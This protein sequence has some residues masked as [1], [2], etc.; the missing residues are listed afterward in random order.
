M[1]A[2]DSSVD[3]LLWLVT[4]GFCARMDPPPG[5]I[6]RQ[7]ALPNRPSRWGVTLDYLVDTDKP[8]C[9]GGTRQ[10]GPREGDATEKE[11]RS[12]TAVPSVFTGSP[13]AE[14]VASGFQF[15][16]GPVWL[17]EEGCLLFSDIP[18]DS[19]LKLTPGGAVSVFREPS[20][21]SNGLTRD[22]HGRLIAC[23][24]G[25]RRVSRTDGD[26]AVAT[27]AERF[28]G[29]RLNSPNDV[30]VRSD[31]LVYFTDPTYGI[32]PT[33]RSF[34]RGLPARPGS[35]ELY[36]RRTTSEGTTHFLPDSRACTSMTRVAGTYACF[37]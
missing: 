37:R 20:A 3:G 23:E 9:R 30:V 36:P 10:V 29:K 25:N 22:R 32:R 6:P 11:W 21:N 24:H 16:E 31:G 34:L 15:T 26:G 1:R 17:I 4:T 33:S 35:R 7:H 12:P 2:G 5:G 19:I 8:R 27:L 28:K 13:K 14:R 18:A